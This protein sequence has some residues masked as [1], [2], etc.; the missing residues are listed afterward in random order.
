[1]IHA[2]IKRETDRR[3]DYASGLARE[4]QGGHGGHREGEGKEGAKNVAEAVAEAEAEAERGDEDKGVSDLYDEGFCCC[5]NTSS[6]G[7]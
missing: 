2:K 1:M 5:N 3:F 7:E 6:S 4:V